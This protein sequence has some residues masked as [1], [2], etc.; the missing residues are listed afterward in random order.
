[1]NGKIKNSLKSKRKIDESERRET[2]QSK[3]M[4]NF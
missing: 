4:V 3:N 2:L 1:M